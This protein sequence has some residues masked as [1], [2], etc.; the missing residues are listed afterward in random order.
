MID[1]FTVFHRGGVILY[2]HELNHVPGNPIDGLIQNV[3]MEERTGSSVGGN[4]YRH[5]DKYTVKWIFNNELDLVFVAVYLNLTNLL[6]LDDLLLSARDKFSNMFRS[7]I[8]SFEPPIVYTK[9]FTRIL[10]QIIYGF[11]ANKHGGSRQIESENSTIEKKTVDKKPTPAA[12]A[13]TTAEPAAAA[14]EDAA[15]AAPTADQ[16]AKAETGVNLSKLAALQ[17][18]ARTGKPVHQFGKKKKPTDKAAEP[19]PAE[20]PNKKVKVARTWLENKATK[21]EAK[22]LDYTRVIDGDKAVEA[23]SV[24]SGFD[25]KPKVDANN[26]YSKVEKVS[27][28][29][30][31]DDD[32]DVDDDDNVDDASASSASSVG[33]G[34]GLFSFLKTLVAG[35]VLE[36]SDLEPVLQ[37]F[38]ELLNGKN[39]AADISEQLAESVIKTLEGQKLASFTSVKSMVK[40]AVE[41]ALTRI[42]TP[43]RQIDILAGVVEANEQ[44]RPYSIVFVGVNGVG[45]VSR[46]TCTPPRSMGQRVLPFV[47]AR[48][49]AWRET[50]YAAG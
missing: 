34:G 36:R 27:Y 28:S 6:Y 40:K 41:A 18:A 33:S 26:N 43:N 38:K 7:E 12:A 2:K 31:E 4:S 11:E 45:K 19:T 13:P 9:K 35:K 50:T 46:H 30:D 15:T 8:L 23:E 25:N 29:D 21:A 1:L 32:G 37:Q 39:V 24:I 49:R 17:Q 14:S 16:P 3:L 47:Q 42:L 10:D 44:K 22:A 5:D 48:P 20:A